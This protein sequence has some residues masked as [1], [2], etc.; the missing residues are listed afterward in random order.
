MKKTPYIQRQL[1]YLS[2]ITNVIFKLGITYFVYVILTDGI[3]FTHDVNA[4]I[5]NTSE[6]WDK[7]LK[8][9]G[10]LIKK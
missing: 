4:T 8:I 9:L 7:A 10:E 5:L 1:S 2:Q 3:T 6:V